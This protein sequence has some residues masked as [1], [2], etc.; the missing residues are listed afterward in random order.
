M[1]ADKIKEHREEFD[2]EFNALY[3]MNVSIFNGEPVIIGNPPVADI[4]NWHTN[5]IKQILQ[6]LI[7]RLETKKYKSD[8]D[9]FGYDPL[10][11]SPI[12]ANER[13]VNKSLQDTIDYLKS[14]LACVE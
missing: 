6:A 13:A 10:E 12:Y 5:S 4:M 2:K 9:R 1:I 8:K 7:E 3:G 11:H 14:E